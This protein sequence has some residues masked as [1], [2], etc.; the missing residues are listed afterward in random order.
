MKGRFQFI[1]IGVVFPLIPLFFIDFSRADLYQYVD[2]G[3]VLCFSN[4]P[5]NGHYQAIRIKEKAGFFKKQDPKTY[6][7][8]ILSSSR[9]Y[10][11]DP[12]LVRSMIRAESSFNPLAL[13]SSGAMGLMQLMPETADDMLVEDPFDP[14]QNIEGGTRYI[15]KLL[16]RFEGRLSVALAAWHA[17][18]SLV[19]QYD[20]IP[21]IPKTQTFVKRVLRFYEEYR[22]Q[23][24]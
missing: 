2:E 8:Y 19:E 10:N 15:R 22:L 1:M 18:P 13:S 9:K 11:L 17:G 5:D 16:D 20:E 4:V 24:E 6:D 23:R 3:G 14:G 7:S 21:P 12:L